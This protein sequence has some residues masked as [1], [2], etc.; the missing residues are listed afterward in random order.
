MFIGY[1]RTALAGIEDPELRVTFDTGLRWRD[2]ELDLC[3]G[4]YG[5][6]I[7]PEGDILMEIKIP[8]ACPLWLSS[9]LSAVGA[10]PTSFSK[11]GACYCWHLLPK[12][13]AE[14]EKEVRFCA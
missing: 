3:A 13:A 1:D 10:F 8:G 12:A 7:L 11:Y 4:D 2:T 6:P 14:R 5:A 9:A